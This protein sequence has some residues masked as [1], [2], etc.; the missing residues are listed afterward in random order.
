MQTI[1]KTAS[2]GI[3]ELSGKVRYTQEHRELTA[4]KAQRAEL[5]VKINKLEAA[6]RKAG[7][8]SLKRKV[9]PV[10]WKVGDVVKCMCGDTD[11]ALGRLYKIANISKDHIM[12]QT[13]PKKYRWTSVNNFKLIGR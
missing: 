9:I 13:S 8:E 4:M 5:D 6:L 1:Y 10:K 7:L 11:F 3:S 12:L 2:L